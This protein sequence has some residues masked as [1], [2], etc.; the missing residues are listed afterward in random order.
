MLLKIGNKINIT[1]CGMM[2]SGK[3]SIGKLIAKKINYNF[4]DTDILI[5]KKENKS[6]NQIFAENGEEYFRALEKKITLNYLNNKKTIISLG[7]GAILNKDI[8]LA[9]KLNSF[10]IYLKSN[11]FVLK[12]RLESSKSRPLLKNVILDEK[13]DELLNQREKFYNNADLIINNDK[14]INNTINEILKF[15]SYK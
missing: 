4:I 15:I 2:G 6:I 5:E 13:L 11:K 12:K 8:R 3:S 9:I 10:N 1:I 14:K 7:G